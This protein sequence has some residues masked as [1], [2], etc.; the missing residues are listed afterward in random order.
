MGTV[1]S[2]TAP[3]LTRTAKYATCLRCVRC[4]RD[5]TTSTASPLVRCTQAVLRKPTCSVRREPGSGGCS[6]GSRNT[7]PKG[8]YLKRKRGRDW[9]RSSA[10]HRRRS[11]DSTGAG[12]ERPRT[13]EKGQRGV[14]VDSSLRTNLQMK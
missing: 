3:R 13:L 6:Q 14:Q 12:T 10:R 7:S 8:T 1:E 9:R 2:T 5:G 4:I 11:L